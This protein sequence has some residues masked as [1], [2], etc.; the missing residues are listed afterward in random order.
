MPPQAMTSQLVIDVVTLAIGWFLKND[1][2]PGNLDGPIEGM[3]E[4]LSKPD[5]D[6]DRCSGLFFAPVHPTIKRRQ[7]YFLH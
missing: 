4:A 5:V 1:Y 7:V 6:S 3:D 2:S